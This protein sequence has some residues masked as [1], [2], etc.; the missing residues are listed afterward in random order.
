MKYLLDTDICIYTIKT[1]PPGVA[2][3]LS[4]A[5]PGSVGISAITYAEL[6]TGAYKSLYIEDNL[7]RLKQLATR[8]DIVAFDEKAASV[9]GQ[10]RADLEKRGQGIG[11]LDLLIAASA[12]A[13]QLILVTNNTAEFSRIKGLEL[14]NWADSRL[15]E[16]T[17]GSGVFM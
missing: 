10:I 17:P 15:S 14:E 16:N 8:L 5:E 7:A 1:K 9:Y 12:L 4:Q 3:R 13:R 6:M 11:S 2:K